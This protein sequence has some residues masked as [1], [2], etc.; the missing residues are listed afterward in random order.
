MGVPVVA[1]SGDYADYG[2]PWDEM[3]LNIGTAVGQPK[4]A[5]ALIDDVKTRISDEAAA[6]P[7][8][9]GQTAAVITPYE[10]LFLYGPED[11][12]SRMLLDLGFSCTR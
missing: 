10:G 7:E 4:A 11:P 5:Q 2:M 12:R 6:H 8:F 9:K 1:Q 3:A